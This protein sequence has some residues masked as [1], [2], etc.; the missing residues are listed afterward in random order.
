MA[1]KWICA[2]SKVIELVGGHV[3]DTRLGYQSCARYMPTTWHCRLMVLVRL[4]IDG[5]PWNKGRGPDILLGAPTRCCRPWEEV[6][7]TDQVRRSPG[8]G[9]GLVSRLSPCKPEVQVL[10]CAVLV[11]AV[12]PQLPRRGPVGREPWFSVAFGEW[13]QQSV[14]RCQGFPGGPGESDPAPLDP[15]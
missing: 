7:G 3:K 5:C 6:Q 4:C 8:A 1:W 13:G 15:R 11:S 14:A 9:K 12:S 2:L 10:R